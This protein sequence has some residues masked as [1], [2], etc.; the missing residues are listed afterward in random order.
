MP[1][2]VQS[3][4]FPA[5][6]AWLVAADLADKPND[7]LDR[8]GAGAA[9]SVNISPEANALVRDILTLKVSDSGCGLRRLRN[10]RDALL[11]ESQL[12]VTD[13]AGSM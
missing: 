9:S 4:D 5:F 2:C 7:D 12:K 8:A 1:C 11:G 3:R 13:G 6:L 10:L